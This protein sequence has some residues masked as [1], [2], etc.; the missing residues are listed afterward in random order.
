[1]ENCATKKATSLFVI[2]SLRFS[3][4]LRC[5]AYVHSAVSALGARLTWPVREKRKKHDD[6][7]RDSGDEDLEFG[8]CLMQR[9]S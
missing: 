5:M 9:V 1:M 6:I 8:H 3:A 7:K 4:R 2:L